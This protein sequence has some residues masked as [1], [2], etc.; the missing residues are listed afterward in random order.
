MADK[1]TGQED[2]A[3][4]NGWVP[5]E[6]WKEQGREEDEWV[7]AKEFNLR[8]ELMGRISQQTKEIKQLQESTK[9]RDARLSKLS[10][11]LQALG[12][13]NRKLAKRRLEEEREEL[14]RI[15]AEALVNQDSETVADVDSDLRE[16]DKQEAALDA[17]EKTTPA[18]A[19][20]E[21]QQQSMS[22]EQQRL[23]AEWVR[24]NPW[25]VTDPRA[26]QYANF[27][28][29][30]MN[31]EGRDFS[32]LLDEVKEAVVGVFNLDDEDGAPP[33]RRSAVMDSPAKG[34]PPRK[35]EGDL[36]TKLSEGQREIGKT[37]VEEGLFDNLSEYAKQLQELGELGS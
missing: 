34:T 32:E 27:V 18:D 36:T 35:R 4:N 26:Q 37:F 12:E 21:Q 22:P 6:E 28:A 14:T 16:L 25:Y 9:Q 30:T 7:D 33:A 19:V 24:D 5:L 20:E 29:A 8:G 31:T 10:E 23:W 15:R 17:E 3:R 2:K 1:P 13:Q 11:A